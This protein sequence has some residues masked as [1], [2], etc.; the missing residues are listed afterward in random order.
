MEFLS[1]NH[2]RSLHYFFFFLQKKQT[3]SKLGWRSEAY[4]Q[5]DVV[6]VCRRHMAG[7]QVHVSLLQGLPILFQ[8]ETYF[9]SKM[10]LP[11]LHKKIVLWI[12]LLARL[13]CIFLCVICNNIFFFTVERPIIICVLHSV[14]S[15][16]NMFHK[17][18]KLHFLNYILFTVSHTESYFSRSM[19]SLLSLSRFGAFCH[20]FPP[21]F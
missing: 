11:W 7:K 18:I 21:Q 14:S 19:R 8:W 15:I 20:F 1:F 16:F 3:N 5:N 2:G 10:T 13:W 12:S 6:T 9:L 17:Y 4:E